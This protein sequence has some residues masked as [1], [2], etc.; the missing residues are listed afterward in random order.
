MS[1]AEGQYGNAALWLDRISKAQK[2]D[3]EW[4][5]EA[6]AAIDRFSLTGKDG[7]WSGRGKYNILWS[8]TEVLKNAIYNVPP[9]P[10]VRQRWDTKDPVA[11]ATAETLDRA[12]T[13]TIE[14]S[15]FDYVA[16]QAMYDFLLAGRSTIRVRYD[17]R[18]EPVTGPDGQPMLDM[19]G[20]PAEDIRDEFIVFDRVNYR[21]F[22]HS[23]A[24]CWDK[25]DWVAFRHFLTKKEATELFGQESVLDMAFTASITS[26]DEDK[27]GEWTDSDSKE[28]NLA[29][30][31]EIWCKSSSAVYWVASGAKEDG[32]LK[33]EGPPLEL[34]GFFPTPQPLY[35]IQTPEVL[36]A[37]TL[38]SQYRE[39][40]EE[41][42]RTSARLKVMVGTLKYRG[43]YDPSLSSDLKRTIES[44]SDGE[45]APAEN[46]MAWVERGGLAAAVWTMPIGEAITAVTSLYQAREQTKAAIFEITGISDV[47]RGN[48]NPNETATAQQIKAQWGS[49]RV[50][51]MKRKV[52]RY[53]K[54]V[55]TIASEV[56]GET[57]GIQTLADMT[58][59][60][61]PS[62]QE[63]QQAQMQLQQIQQYEQQAQAMQQ[64]LP[65]EL[66]NQKRTLEETAK[67][68]SWE[69]VKEILSS[70]R[71]RGFK[72]DIETDSTI[73]PDQRA[74]TQAL[75]ESMQILT[76]SM[77]PIMAGLQSGVL[78][79]R[80]AISIFSE[81]VRKTPLSNRLTSILE[82]YE[83]ELANGNPLQREL[84]ELKNEN[85]QLKQQVES[86]QGE[87]AVKAAAVQQ[88]EKQSDGEIALGSQELQLKAEEARQRAMF[89]GMI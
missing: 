16:E 50:D 34:E 54:E 86:K 78:P 55:L 49:S 20:Q 33:E 32:I 89:G 38:Y 27:S 17:M 9:V 14:R 15:G 42:D 85:Q 10:D 18:A 35:A 64:P 23:E 66:Q 46:A 11:L 76:S 24:S 30:V 62:A 7:K 44:L 45:F 25:V 72:I 81:I 5:K 41:L 19:M 70:D 4:R 84:D 48:T 12:L 1:E 2:R 75:G 83:E 22:L 51:G 37:I 65:P 82:E 3:E 6:K 68:A 87:L 28:G 79:Q 39:Q 59:L 31:W 63:K 29:V 80:M 61:Y 69:E 74:E 40:A 13:Y 26:R 56:I 21:D 57:F 67:K 73:A 47:L 77:G 36:G 71:L 52:Q 8:N 60:K 88:K 53:F 43:L 58:G